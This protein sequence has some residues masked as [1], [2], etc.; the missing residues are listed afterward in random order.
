ARRSAARRTWRVRR[1]HPAG[2]RVRRARASVREGY[3]RPGHPVTRARLLAAALA[4][5][6]V[7]APA[8]ARAG[9]EEFSTFSVE[10]QEE[11]DESV[12]DHMLSRAPRDWRAEWERAPLAFRTQ[13][14]CLTSGQ[15]LVHNDLKLETALGARARFGVQ[16]QDYE[17]DVASY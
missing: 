11:D 7:C 6:V 2:S 14:G 5:G 15:W 9:T 16:L 10:R 1:D 3:G 4:L 8:A 13:Q 12:L 17:D